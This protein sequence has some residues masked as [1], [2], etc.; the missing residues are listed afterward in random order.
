MSTDWVNG[1]ETQSQCPHVCKGEATVLLFLKWCSLSWASCL[2]QEVNEEF[3]AGGY[4]LIFKKLY[5]SRN[6]W[7]SAVNFFGK[8]GVHVLGLY[9]KQSIWFTIYCPVSFLPGSAQ[10]HLKPWYKCKI[11]LNCYYFFHFWVTSL[12]LNVER[13]FCFRLFFPQC[14]FLPVELVWVGQAPDFCDS[15][16]AYWTMRFK[17][18]K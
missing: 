7:N 10:I 15:P 5:K 11:S 12:T 1:L 4:Y 16:P 13:T 3:L 9:P 14:H 18:W 8:N 2:N 6:I 17:C